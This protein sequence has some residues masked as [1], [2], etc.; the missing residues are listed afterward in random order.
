MSF[1]QSFSGFRK[2][3]KDKLL[4]MGRK[5]DQTPSGAGGE[6]LGHSSL[7][8]PSES[9]IVVEG[10]R[11]GG[12]SVGE[13][14]GDPQLDDSRSVSQSLARREL[15]GSDDDD[16]RPEGDQEGLRPHTHLQAGREA[17]REGKKVDVKGVDQDPSK[18]GVEKTTP[19][20]SVSHA[21]GSGST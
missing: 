13:G 8:L 18:S 14:E 21:G 4:K 15:G 6:G 16:N 11:R 17:S 5:P 19:A 7:S 9:A 12:T 3:A 1:K 20:P 10:E 2:K